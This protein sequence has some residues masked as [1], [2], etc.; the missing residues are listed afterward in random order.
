MRHILAQASDA[1]LLNA[2]TQAVAFYRARRDRA[3]TRNGWRTRNPFPGIVKVGF[4]MIGPN[5]CTHSVVNFKLVFPGFSQFR[6]CCR[7]AR[8]SAPTPSTI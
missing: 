3:N 6:R 8:D 5:L 7:T 4:G 2:D 1:D